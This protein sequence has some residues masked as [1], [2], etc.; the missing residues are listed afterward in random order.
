MN[1]DMDGFGLLADLPPEAL[2]QLL[3]LGTLDER[4]QLLANQ[5]AQ[6][7][8]LQNHATAQRGTVGGAIGSGLGGVVDAIRG[9][10]AENQLRQQQQS[11][12]GQKDAGR[13]AYADA[14]RRYRLQRMQQVPPSAG[15]GDVPLLSPGMG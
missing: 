9:G 3:A 1:G 8:A 7:Q 14:L 13:S 5:M 4:G 15:M 12:L 6:A 10:L 11:L 2:Q